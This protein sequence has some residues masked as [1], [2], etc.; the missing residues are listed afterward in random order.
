[1][2]KSLPNPDTRRCSICIYHD[3]T[4][5][6][7]MCYY[8]RGAG[9]EERKILICRRFPPT[10]DGFPAVE[11]DCWC[12]EFKRSLA[13]TV[14]ETIKALKDNCEE[15]PEQ[16]A[17]EHFEWVSFRDLLVRFQE[18]RAL[19]HSVCAS[20]IPGIG[21]YDET[22]NCTLQTPLVKV[23]E[24]VAVREWLASDAYMRTLLEGM[25]WSIAEFKEKIITPKGRQY[26]F[27]EHVLHK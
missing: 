1:M 11:K 5:T 3:K 13:D 24:C 6:H 9:A 14:L 17:E 20:D 10:T 26:L 16:P 12:W 8:E 7:A 15:Q 18:A 23:K 21:W 19:G 4:V 22:A 27:G 2:K 25:P